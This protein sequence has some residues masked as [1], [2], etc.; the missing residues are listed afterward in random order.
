MLD[1]DF[2]N[3]EK[4][5]T[6]K[7]F[8][9]FKSRLDT[10]ILK[11]LEESALGEEQLSWY[12]WP[13][14][15]NRE[16]NLNIQA[17]AA[18][19]RE[20]SDVFVVISSG[21]SYLGSKAILDALLPNFKNIK[22]RNEKQDPLI[23]FAGF[24]FSLTYLQDLISLL[25]DKDFSL[26]L[27]SKDGNNLETSL[28]FQYL[29]AYLLDRYGQAEAKERTYFVTGS[30]DSPLN[31]Q[32]KELASDCFTIPYGLAS[33]FD[34]LT[35]SGLFPLAVAGFN[36]D[37]FL[38]GA[39]DQKLHFEKFKGGA[40]VSLY[41]LFRLLLFN[42]GFKKEALSVFEPKLSSFQKWWEKLANFS[43]SGPA[44]ALTR[45]SINY[46]IDLD[47]N[48]E[49]LV[50]DLND[51]F[52]SFIYVR[53]LNLA[54]NKNITSEFRS[55]DLKSIYNLKLVETKIW[56]E[57]SEAKK[58]NETPNLTIKIDNLDEYNIGALIFFFEVS[59][60]LTRYML[61]ESVDGKS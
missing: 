9:Q 51:F 54:E 47:L 23:V 59:S 22:T 33:E 30:N 40:G 48:N 14:N 8:V 45:F 19:I 42:K 6:E 55:E 46:P 27:I 57:I 43:Q 61:G 20:N 36:I 60:V 49:P 56:Q 1:V 50:N 12:D 7:D 35:A 21:P 26:C 16:E 25:K 10:A 24:D 52:E 3:L 58:D 31:K 44:K 15:Y 11:L 39:L 5:V 37:N 53:D 28:S 17:A 38:Q 41:S 34:I 32:A 4:F 18:Q 2:Q 29:G 13:V